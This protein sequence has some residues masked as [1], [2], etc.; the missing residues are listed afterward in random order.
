MQYDF[1]SIINDP[2]THLLIFV[3]L[4]FLDL[5]KFIYP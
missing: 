2:Y 1:Q 4:I 3:H 5:T